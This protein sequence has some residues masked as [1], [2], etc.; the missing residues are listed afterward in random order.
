[1]AGQL[2]GQVPRRS[3][4][5]ADGAR[6][7]LKYSDP[8]NAAPDGWPLGSTQWLQQG[9]QGMSAK[10]LGHVPFQSSIQFCWP[11]RFLRPGGRDAARATESMG[12]S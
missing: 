11:A 10:S 1:M 9:S 8:I 2:G 6:R 4:G 12:P 5:S 3:S 7:T